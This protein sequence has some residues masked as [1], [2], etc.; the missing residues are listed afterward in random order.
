[1]HR[2]SLSSVAAVALAPRRPLNVMV[3]SVVGPCFILWGLV[4][5]IGVN[6]ILPMMFRCYWPMVGCLAVT[7][8]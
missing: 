1:M 8:T 2:L 4:L 5:D 7:P 3:W 6:C